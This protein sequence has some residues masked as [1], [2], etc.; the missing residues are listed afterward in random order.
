MGF[1][2]TRKTTFG[3]LGAM[4]DFMDLPRDPFSTASHWVKLPTGCAESKG[5][6]ERRAF[7]PLDV[8]QEVVYLS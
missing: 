3:R 4:Q 6:R 7:D 2:V 8:V 1:F 5:T